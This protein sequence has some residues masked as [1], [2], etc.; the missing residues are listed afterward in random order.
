MSRVVVVS[1]G[2]RGLGEAIVRHLLKQGDTVCTFSR[3]R[4]PAMDELEAGENGERFLF[5]SVD[6]ADSDAV[7]ACLLYTSPSP[8]D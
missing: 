8:R 6:I 7:R 5:E 2:S 3:S 4:T 1:G